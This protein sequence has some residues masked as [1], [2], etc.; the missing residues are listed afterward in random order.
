MAKKYNIGIIGA[1]MIA[2]H[3]IESFI[4]SQR[5]QISWVV[6][7]NENILKKVAKKYAIRNTT[8]NYTDVLNDEHVDAVVICTPPKIHKTIFIDAVK[9]GK[10]VLVEKPAAMSVNEMDEMIQ[11]LQENPEVT[12]LDCSC[13]HSRLQPKYIKIK[14][15][16]DKGLLGDIYLIHHNHVQRQF[17]P[18]IEY[19]PDAKWFLNKQVA[20]GGPLF[21][22]GVYD[23]AF[24]LGILGDKYDLKQVNSIATFSGLDNYK[25]GDHIYDVEEH[26]TSALEFTN[27]LKYYWERGTHA[28]VEVPNETR[29]YGSRGG[30]KVSYCSWEG[31]TIEFYTLD[32]NNKAQQETLK[33]NAKEHDD[34]LALVDHFMNVIEGKEQP[35]M[36]IATAK[37]HL[38][39]IFKIYKENKIKTY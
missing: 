20:G 17:R 8:V 13:R 26:F 18:G 31:E 1:G 15:L 28:N 6:D 39:I 24:H 10:H 14:E 25:A 33:V 19:H 37:K 32:K 35:A 11:I 36:P 3:H 21:D 16:I 29:I 34:A 12:A 22:W 23:L 5:A 2:E 4:K 30:I 9:A 38:E 27:G 7:L